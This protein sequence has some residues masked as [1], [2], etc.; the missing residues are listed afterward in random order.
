[1]LTQPIAGGMI[2]QVFDAKASEN[3]WREGIQ[4]ARIASATGEGAIRVMPSLSSPHPRDS[5]HEFPCDGAQ[6]ARIATA[7]G[8]GAIT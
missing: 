2:G 5:R 7:T 1:M 4:V 3:A 6:V 8:E